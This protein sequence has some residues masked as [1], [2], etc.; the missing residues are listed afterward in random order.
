[1]LINHLLLNNLEDLDMM[2]K[3]M[4]QMFLNQYLLNIMI[5]LI[6]NKELMKMMNEYV[7]LIDHSILMDTVVQIEK[8]VYQQIFGFDH[9][10]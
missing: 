2:V 1:M 8:E 7:N 3:K 6:Q 9:L 5:N 4:Y 10:H